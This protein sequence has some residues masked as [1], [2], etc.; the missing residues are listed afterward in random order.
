MRAVPVVLLWSAVQGA[1][2]QAVK[3]ADSTCAGCAQA[4]AAPMVTPSTG[5]LWAVGGGHVIGGAFIYHEMEASWGQS[6]G[7]LHVKWNDW[8]CDGLMQNDE[9]SHFVSGYHLTKAFAHLW[10]WTGEPTKRARTWG[11]LEAGVILTLVELPIDAFNPQQGLGIS[12]LIFD[13]GGVG[14]GLL[15]LHQPGRWDFKFSAKHN[16]FATQKTLFSQNSRDS[17]NYVFWATYRPSFG[18][19]ER[20]PL[21]VGLGHGVGREANGVTP[22]REL[23]L[24][25]GTTIPDVV[26][27]AAPGVARHIQLLEAYYINVRL[28]ATVR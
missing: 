6:N 2:A 22:V 7:R 16:V 27:L 26:R 18:L 4:A 10:S 12:D 21:S 23:Y 24:G 3:L 19:D 25:L 15:A 5:R 1:G 11:A 13:Y 17:D 20:Q 28:R 8:C 14:M 9:I